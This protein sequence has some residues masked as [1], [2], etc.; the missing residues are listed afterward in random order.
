M[1]GLATIQ[2]FKQEK[3]FHKSLLKA[4]ELHGSW[5]LSFFA[6]IRWFGFRMD[7]IN[8]SI[9][10]ATIV[11]AIIAVE[12]V[13]VEVL[14]VALTHML[15]LS[16]VLQWCLQQL[17]ELEN[18]MTAA[19][20]NLEYTKLEQEPSKTPKEGEKSL[21][22]WPT[23][24][25]VEINSMTASYRPGLEPVLND[26]TFKIP[27]G[28]SVGIVGRTGSGKSSLLLT[29]FRLIDINKGSICINGIDTSELKLDMLRKQIAVIPQDPVLFGGTFRSNLDPHKKLSDARLW[30][31][32]QEVHLDSTVTE[33][34]GLNALIS[35][36]GNNL[37]AG[38]R[39]L[40]CLARALLRDSRILVLD[41]ATANVDH[42]TDVLIQHSLHSL[43]AE[44]KKT[45]LIIAHRIDTILDCDLLVVLQG[46]K[47]VEY[48]R[49]T[50]LLAQQEGAFKQMVEAAERASKM[51][52]E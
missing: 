28:S 6:A 17:A 36:S 49:P 30:T 35:E 39:Q 40:L 42:A 4:V 22:G 34:G 15:T 32:L 7:G 24:G 14:A 1:K 13:S 33:F 19:E 9:T 18:T 27:G 29:L 41:E 51:C 37:S 20:R 5:L 50:E 31:A 45:L 26:I 43:I 2:T 52:I 48:G 21:E 11:T 16:G 23:E 8:V 44:R 38:Q 12:N 46:G 10:F 3:H 47:L 25:S